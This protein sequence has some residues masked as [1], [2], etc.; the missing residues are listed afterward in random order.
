MPVMALLSL[1]AGCKAPGPVL[2]DGNCTLDPS[3]GLAYCY[4]PKGGPVDKHISDLPGYTCFSPDDTQTLLE[5]I[6]R[7]EDRCGSKR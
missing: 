1:L 6:K 7:T 4:P 3:A 2:K 5:W